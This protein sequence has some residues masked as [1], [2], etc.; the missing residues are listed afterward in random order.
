MS[1]GDFVF[2]IVEPAQVTRDAANRGF[3]EDGDGR[4]SSKRRRIESGGR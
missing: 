4:Y 2:D 3:S 1:G